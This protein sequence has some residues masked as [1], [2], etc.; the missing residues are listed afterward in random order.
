[1]ANLTWKD[2]EA[3]AVLLKALEAGDIPIDES[4][5]SAEDVYSHVCYPAF[6]DFDFK[7]FKTNLKSLRGKVATSIRS[8]EW[9]ALALA[10]DE[11][12]YPRPSHNYRGEPRW[13]GSDAQKLLKTTVSVAWEMGIDDNM[14]TVDDLL[15][16][17]HKSEFAGFK[18]ETIGKH[19][20]QEVRSI[21]FGN[22][23]KRV[24]EESIKKDE[25]KWAKAKHQKKN[26]K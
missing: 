20:H 26:S 22:Y 11:L 19:I 16:L 5:M 13:E 18:K 10:H 7:K 17:A 6:R 15:Q 12:I 3:K 23:L 1:M 25:K 8:A 21:K 4:K 2:S 9:A 24:S 14:P